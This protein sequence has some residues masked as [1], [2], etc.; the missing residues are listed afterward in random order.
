MRRVAI[1]VWACCFFSA[2]QAA[3][4]TQPA[5]LATLFADIYG[6]HGLVLSCDDM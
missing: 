6:P 4:Q 5:S 1:A 2:T 3:A